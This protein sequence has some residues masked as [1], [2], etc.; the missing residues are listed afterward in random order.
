MVKEEIVKET[1]VDFLKNI[2]YIH[3]VPEYTIN[4]YDADFVATDEHKLIAIECKGT[5]GRFQEALG[6][7]IIFDTI[8]LFS[9]SL[10]ITSRY[11]LI[12]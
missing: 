5:G 2:G 7:A 4:G 3:I 1:I 9:K 12:R 10:L 8:P 6:Q 11:G